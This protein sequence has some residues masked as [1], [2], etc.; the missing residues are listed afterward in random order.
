[1]YCCRT[2]RNWSSDVIW[3]RRR[4]TA[5]WGGGISTGKV[6][7]TGAGAT[8]NGARAV[9]ERGRTAA[10]VGPDATAAV[11]IATGLAGRTTMAGNPVRAFIGTTLAACAAVSDSMPSRGGTVNEHIPRDLITSGWGGTSLARRDPACVG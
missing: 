1:M 7:M 5:P 9:A 10:A 11:A 8:G 2:R 6:G 4:S 3:S